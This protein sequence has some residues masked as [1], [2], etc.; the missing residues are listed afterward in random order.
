MRPRAGRAL[1]A[2][3]HV[4]Q[5]RIDHKAVDRLNAR[6][7]VVR[8]GHKA[9]RHVEPTSLSQCRRPDI[10]VTK[11][12][13]WLVEPSKQRRDLLQEVKVARGG[14]LFVGKVDRDQ[15]TPRTN[16]VAVTAPTR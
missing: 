4:T 2:S 9:P 16:K 1:Y 8:R 11:D 10:Q 7:V 12:S 6:A 15:A 3:H 14:A 5:P 13:L